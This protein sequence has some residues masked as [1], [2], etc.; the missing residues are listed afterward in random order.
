MEPEA[1]L[2]I[3]FARIVVVEASEGEA[4]VEQHTSIGHVQNVH[5]DGGVLAYGPGGREVEG[6]VLGQVVSWIE[7]VWRAVM[8]A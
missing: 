5:R 7:G 4:V 3:N 1:H 2:S 6:G 8:E